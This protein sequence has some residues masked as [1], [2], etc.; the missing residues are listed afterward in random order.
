[1]KA[2]A[3]LW[4]GDLRSTLRLREYADHPEPVVRR[5]LALVGQ[6][7]NYQFLLAEVLLAEDDPRLVAILENLVLYGPAP[8]AFNAFDDHFDRVALYVDDDG[9]PVEVDR[10]PSGDDEDH[11]KDED[12]DDDH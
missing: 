10:R 6:W 1:L 11:D 7:Y 8:D 9:N 12:G 3:A 4:C 2:L 5:A